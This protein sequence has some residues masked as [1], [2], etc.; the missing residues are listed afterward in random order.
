MFENNVGWFSLNLLQD[1]I[2]IWF[3]FWVV[4]TLRLIPEVSS[5]LK[6]LYF[7]FSCHKSMKKNVI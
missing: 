7:T 2:V 3:L 1:V 4:L 6:T 5:V